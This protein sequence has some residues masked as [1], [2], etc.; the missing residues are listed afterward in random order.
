MKI[1]LLIMTTPIKHKGQIVERV[2]RQSG[3]TITKIAA[4]LKISRNT[5][6]NKFSNPNLSPEFIKKVGKIINHDFS[7]EFTDM[8]REVEEGREKTSPYTAKGGIEISRLMKEYFALSKKHRSLLELLVKLAN[9][10][11]IAAIKKEISRFL[12]ANDWASL[13]KDGGGDSPIPG[14]DHDKR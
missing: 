8:K 9:E 7:V 4:R 11:D 5:L 3:Y 10:D 14:S 1:N 12:E 13:Q 2:S 6:Y